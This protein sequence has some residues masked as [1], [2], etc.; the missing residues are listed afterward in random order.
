MTDAH[1]SSAASG[2]CIGCALTLLGFVLGLGVSV[3][4]IWW[5]LG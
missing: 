3:A 2:G 5:R 1:D 4:V